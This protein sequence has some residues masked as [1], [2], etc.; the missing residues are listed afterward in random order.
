MIKKESFNRVKKMLLISNMYP[1]NQ[2][3]TYGVFVKNFEKKMKQN[4]FSIT[5]KCVIEGRG[6][7]IFE[8][9][10]LVHNS[11]KYD[12]NTFTENFITTVNNLWQKKQKANL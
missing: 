4:G 2:H 8:K 11:R 1:S 3:P 9:T 7:N 12:T 6:Q 10:R 5:Q